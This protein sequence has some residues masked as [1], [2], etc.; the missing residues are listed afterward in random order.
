[1]SAKAFAPVE[2][3]LAEDFLPALLSDT[4]KTTSTLHDLLA[5]PVRF[6]GLGIPDPR[7]EATTHFDMSRGATADLI[8][9]LQNSEP[10]DA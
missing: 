4:V 7:T 2:K 1:M 5:F 6:S 9:S 8:A 10:L 3:A